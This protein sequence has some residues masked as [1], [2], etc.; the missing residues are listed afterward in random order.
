MT[1]VMDYTGEFESAAIGLDAGHVVLRD[2]HAGAF[3]DPI[4][5]A[6]EVSAGLSR[7]GDGSPSQRR[8]LRRPL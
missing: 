5:Y 8:A 7:E 3:G 2:F 6:K 1:Q 4:A